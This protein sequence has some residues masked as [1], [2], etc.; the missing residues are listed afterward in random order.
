MQGQACKHANT[1]NRSDIYQFDTANRLENIQ[2]L[3]SLSQILEQVNYGYDANG[4]RTS[5][6][7]PTE[8][9]EG[10]VFNFTILS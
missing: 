5:M 8:S 10:Q 4:N 1:N 2:H 9:R 7:R 6:N 3:N